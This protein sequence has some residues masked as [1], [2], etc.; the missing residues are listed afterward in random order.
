MRIWRV[1]LSGYLVWIC[2]LAL[3][4]TLVAVEATPEAAKKKKAKT[5]P[6]AEFFADP[7]I[8]VFDL[9]IAEADLAQLTQNSRTYVSADLTEGKIV[10]AKIG[11][12]L[13]GMGSFRPVDDKPSFAIKFDEFDE[14]QTYR[15]LKKLMFNNSSQDSTYVAEM[16]AT[17]LFTDAG[18]PAARV[19]HARL[20]LNGRDL[21]LYVVIE[22]MNKDFLKRQF[23]SGKGSLYEGYLQ[24][25][26]GDLDQDNGEDESRADLKALNEACAIADP[27][28]RWARLN[29]VLDV[30]RFLSFIAMEL[31]A[32]HWDGYLIHYNN[33]RLYHDPKT[34]KMVFITHGL[35]WAFRRPNVSIDPPVKSVVARAVL[36]TPEG[37]ERYQTRLRSLFAD[38]FKPAVIL[39]RMEQALGRIRQAGLKE[40][41]LAFVE[42]RAGMMRERIQ[43]RVARVDEQLRGVPPESL[44]FDKSGFGYPVT[45]REDPDVGD[46]TADREK[47]QEK[48]TL[49]I[50]ARPGKTRHSWRSQLCMLPGWYHFEGMACTTGGGSARLRISGDNNS[51]GV[52]GAADWQP[53]AHDFY[54]AEGSL[55]VELIC[56]LNATQGGDVWFDLN[57]L[58][59]KRIDA[60]TER[61]NTR[62][63]PALRR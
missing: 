53:L 38:V 52:S 34:G 41:Q 16:L 25:I 31:L 55:D 57:S 48:D 18:V 5:D 30:E 56:E 9:K 51:S 13:K 50:Q 15:G 14:A 20:R 60:P 11:V 42:Q 32:T 59:V 12:R 4:G 1:R 37:K 27:Q 61:S 17:Q 24:D 49:H 23:G 44:K 10:L 40:S 26:D 58:R 21:G 33:Y 43:S 22:A 54:V 46:S 45:W 8:H 63:A 39:E 2:L 3:G 19:T 28:K 36:T 6:G 7:K 62:R 29:E 35:D 47:H